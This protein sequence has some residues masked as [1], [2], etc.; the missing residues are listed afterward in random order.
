VS[1][2]PAREHRGVVIAPNVAREYIEAVDS[3]VTF[4]DAGITTAPYRDLEPYLMK[5]QARSPTVE[6]LARIPPR[7][8]A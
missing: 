5:G 4:L 6:E 8:A 2:G 3:N 7:R 1:G